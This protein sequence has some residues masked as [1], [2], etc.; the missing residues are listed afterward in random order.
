MNHLYV[1]NNNKHLFST[2][3]K[4]KSFIFTSYDITKLSKVQKVLNDHHNVTKTWIKNIQNVYLFAEDHIQIDMTSTNYCS[5]NEP[6]QNLDITFF[7]TYN[8][9]DMLFLYQLTELMNTNVYVIKDY[10][11]SESKSDWDLPLLS[12]QGFFVEYKP[13]DIQLEINP[14]EYLDAMFK[15]DTEN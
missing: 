9:T 13:K 6:V 12:L 5:L 7:D 2:Y 3:A 8:Q 14:S 4:D 1:L 11:Y 10:E 15:I